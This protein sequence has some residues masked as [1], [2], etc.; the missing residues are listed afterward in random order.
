MAGLNSILLVVLTAFVIATVVSQSTIDECDN[1]PSSEIE[2]RIAQLEH[3]MAALILDRLS[4]QEKI[5]Y[6]IGACSRGKLP[7]SNCV[8]FLP[9]HRSLYRSRLQER[10]LPSYG[11]R[12]SGVYRVRVLCRNQQNNIFKNFFH[13]LVESV[14]IMVFPY[15]MAIFYPCEYE[16]MALFDQKIVLSPKRYKNSTR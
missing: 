7:R 5:A 3:K 12:L 9:R 13:C 8:W 1:E 15:I 14:T 10:P 6:C 2:E 4:D 16:K 11:V